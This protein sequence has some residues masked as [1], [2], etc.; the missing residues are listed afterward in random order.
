[1]QNDDQNQE[2]NPYQGYANYQAP[3]RSYSADDLGYPNQSKGFLRNP[4]FATLGLLVGA[5]LLAGVIILSSPAPNEEVL[6]VIKADISPIKVAPEN[7]GGLEIANSDSTVFD[8]LRNSDTND[9]V[10]DLLADAKSELDVKAEEAK[11]AAENI[12]KAAPKSINTQPQ[13]QAIKSAHD[14][15]K[16]PET[17]TAENTAKKIVEK[18]PKQ[19][20]VQVTTQTAPQATTNVALT[21]YVQLASIREESR[22]AEQWKKL[23]SKYSAALGGASYRIQ[24]KDLGTKGIYYRIQAGPFSKTD[25]ADKCAAIKAITPSGCYVVAK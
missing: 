20:P 6:P 23:Q 4:V 21:H 12:I 8:K 3:R 14:A 15:L 10:E 13:T 17:K 11:E 2:N 5:S 7:P 18:R 24:K 9:Q 19:E 1:M 22:A 16:K 25:A